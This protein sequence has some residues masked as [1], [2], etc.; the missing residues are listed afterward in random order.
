MSPPL[1]IF[2]LKK[3]T[4]SRHDR[5]FRIEK[6]TWFLSCNVHQLDK[7]NQVTEGNFQVSH[8]FPYHSHTKKRIGEALKSL[9][10]LSMVIGYYRRL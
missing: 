3:K 8:T 2:C 1:D 7:V 9:V 4:T 5:P 10:H 6:R